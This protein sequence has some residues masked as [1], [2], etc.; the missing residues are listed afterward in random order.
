MRDSVLK[1][2]QHLV[3]I[4][5]LACQWNNKLPQEQ[6]NYKQA[7]LSEHHKLLETVAAHKNLTEAHRILEREIK[8]LKRQL[9]SEAGDSHEAPELSRRDTQFVVQSVAETHFSKVTFGKS[10]SKRSKDINNQAKRIPAREKTSRG[11]MVPQQIPESQLRRSSRLKNRN[12]TILQ[13]PMRILRGR[14]IMQTEV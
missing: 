12:A 13:A 14:Q 2:H 8:I 4:S 1:I 11:R 7:Y 3:D 5:R 9:V 6:K 10:K